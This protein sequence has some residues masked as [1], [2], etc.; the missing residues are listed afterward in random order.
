MNIR[1]E[2]INGQLHE[3]GMICI[4]NCYKEVNLHQ[5]GPGAREVYVL[6]YVISGRGFLE[7]NHK[8]YEINAGDTFLIFPNIEVFYYPDKKN[9]WEY[10]WI[11]F[12]GEEATRL[13]SMTGFTKVSPVVKGKY[14]MKDCF[15]IFDEETPHM[16][17]KERYRA[18][19]H[20]LLTYYFEEKLKKNIENEYI[21]KA[22][23]YI[24]NN[25]W[26]SK[27]NVTSIV[28]YISMER[29]YLF[30]LFKKTTG[31]SM[32][33]YLTTFRIQKAC[34]LL[35]M[36]DLSIKSV[37][38]SVGYED[39]LYFSRIFRK[40]MFISPSDYRNKVQFLLSR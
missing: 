9:P 13:I 33:N 22:I 8:V 28:N 20:L 29:T 31:M 40:I 26:K 23:E 5:W 16:A 1:K 2:D 25:Y 18:R 4:D 27:V 7:V 10:I 35:S 17:R 11:D 34:N 38:Y 12:Q 36:T 21:N 32:V 19:L 24:E 30:R 37:S 15:Y 39:P 3:L 14:G 6:H